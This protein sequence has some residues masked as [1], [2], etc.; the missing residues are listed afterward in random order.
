MTL[1]T[2]PEYLLSAFLVFCRIGACMMT[3]PGFSSPRVAMR[4]RLFLAIAISLS[5]APLLMQFVYPVV[6]G[7]S[8]SDL[9]SMVA[10]EV[11]IGALIGLFGRAFFAML[12]MLA[13]AAANATSFNMA[14]PIVEEREQ[15]PALASLISFVAMGVLFISGTYREVFVALAES[16]LT[17]PVGV[18]FAADAAFSQLVEKVGQGTFLALRITGPFL[19]YGII[20]NL[21]LGLTNR[22]M[23]QM[24]VYF[25]GLPA[26]VFGGLFVLWLTISEIISLFYQGLGDWL[27]L[28]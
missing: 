6:S 17:A 27:T 19:I 2:L 22:L 13:G 20:V 15:L 18:F 7:A 28:R 25:V 21:S 5:L 9:L 3:M 16:Y 23:Q 8:R 12:Q 1:E 14:G 11:L 26:V 4:V 24:P 10:I